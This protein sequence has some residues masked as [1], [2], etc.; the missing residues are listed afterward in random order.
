[1]TLLSAFPLQAEI[2][3]VVERSGP[4]SAMARSEKTPENPPREPQHLLL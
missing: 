2:R 1:M 4:D 3:I